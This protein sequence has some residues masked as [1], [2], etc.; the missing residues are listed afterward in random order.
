MH[1]N[2]TLAHPNT[3]LPGNYAIEV[4]SNTTAT[5][6]APWNY[7]KTGKYAVRTRAAAM[8]AINTAVETPE[9]NNTT[10]GAGVLTLGDDAT[11]FITGQNEGDWFLFVANGPTT[12]AAQCETGVAPGIAGTTIRVYDSA[13]VVLA[14]GSGSTST[15]GRLITTL[16]EG[17][18]YY[19]EV[20]GAVFAGTGNYLLHTGSCDPLFVASSLTTQPPS[21]N[22]CVGSNGLR[23]NLG[24]ANGERP[25][26]G[27]TFV[28]RLSNALPNTIV[29]PMIGLSDRFAA[30]GT[31]PLPFDLGL[32]GAPTCFIRVDPLVTPGFFSDAAGISFVN[33]P[34]L[35]NISSRGTAVFVQC[36][37]FDP[38]LNALG[39]SVS[40]DIRLI[41]G[42]RS[43]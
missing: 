31:I 15:H 23:P 43:F 26:L 16:R 40:N 13:G 11:G 24:T 18:V 20:A 7:L 4:S 36:L 14:T 21:V 38:T 3:L 2:F 39:L 28:L 35:P 10:A 17:G 12:I 19:L 1:R 41:A 34:L 9:P 27:S 30:G 33:F 25:F 37:L 6:T 8:P 32:L 5:G 42:D 22:A 29:V